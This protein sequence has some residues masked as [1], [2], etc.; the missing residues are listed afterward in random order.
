MEN[1]TCRYFKDKPLFGFGYGL[2]YSTFNYHNF[3][4]SSNFKS[5]RGKSLSIRIT[6]TG[7]MQR[8]EVAQLY[9]MHHNLK[10]KSAKKAL[11]GYQRVSL[12]PGESKL[13]YLK[14]SPDELTYIDDKGTKRPLKGEIT[15]SIGGSQPD[16]KLKTSGNIIT[17]KLIIN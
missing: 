15:L 8:D 9:V 5:G 6:N 3:A 7:K 17:K 14:L 16:E 13:V 4:L 12:A 2:S 10:I 1:R 11:K